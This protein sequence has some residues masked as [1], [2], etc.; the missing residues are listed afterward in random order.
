MEDQI[1]ERPQTS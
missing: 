1:M